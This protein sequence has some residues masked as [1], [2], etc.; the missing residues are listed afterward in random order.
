[1]LTPS[2]ACNA[3]VYIPNTGFF[4]S[5]QSIRRLEQR[6]SSLAEVLRSAMALFAAR[7]STL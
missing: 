7:F 2:A 5:F 6:W 1:M 3:L 4:G